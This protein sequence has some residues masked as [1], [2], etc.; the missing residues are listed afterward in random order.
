ML[1]KTSILISQHPL[2]DLGVISGG[3]KDTIDKKLLKWLYEHRLKEKYSSFIKAL[4][5]RTQK[6]ILQYACVQTKNLTWK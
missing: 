1:H 6:I 5:V 3:N 2:G 4:E